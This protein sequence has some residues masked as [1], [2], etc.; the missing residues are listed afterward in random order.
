MYKN[1]F[2][3]GFIWVAVFASTHSFAAIDQWK[4]SYRLES[5]SQYDVAVKIMDAIIKNES[6]ND[7]A[8]MRRGWLNYLRGKH[9]SAIS[10]YKKALTMNKQSLDAKLG[11]I[12]PL[13]AQ[14]RWNEAVK[15][16]KDVLKIAPWN[17]YAHVRLMVAEEGQK[18][19]KTLAKHAD[20]MYRRYPSDATILVYLARAQRWLGDNGAARGAYIKVLKRIPG[21]IEAS[22]FLLE[23]M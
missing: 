14:Q 4:E 21:H 11:V 16:S 23:N 1:I 3:I 19:W 17:Y 15:F 20:E 5:L 12:L 10:D 18:R 8:V 2:F 7:F 22:Q 13:L 9:D 6:K